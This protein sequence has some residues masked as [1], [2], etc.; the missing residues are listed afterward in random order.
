MLLIGAAMLRVPDHSRSFAARFR[1]GFGFPGGRA[2]LPAAVTGHA[3]RAPQRA[4]PPEGCRAPASGLSGSRWD[5]T[6]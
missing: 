6:M 5:S 3:H 2:R 1:S 4:A